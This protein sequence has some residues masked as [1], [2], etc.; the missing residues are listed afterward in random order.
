[1]EDSLLP[2]KRVMRRE[3]EPIHVEAEVC[4]EAEDD[5]KQG[6]RDTVGECA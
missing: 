5:E 2:L 1:M 6:N 3:W 4:P